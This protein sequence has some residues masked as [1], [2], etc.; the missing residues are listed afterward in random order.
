MTVQLIIVST[1]VT[2]VLWELAA[3]PPPTECIVLSATVQLT[4]VS[5]PFCLSKTPPPWSVAVLFRMLLSEIVKL[6]A[7]IT[8]PPETAVLLVMMQ[9]EIFRLAEL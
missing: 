9:S 3:T 4:I 5:W 8:P 6:P 7:F 1:A 2:L